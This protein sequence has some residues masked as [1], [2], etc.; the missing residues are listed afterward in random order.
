MWSTISATGIVYLQVELNSLNS[1]EQHNSNATYV[2]SGHL[3]STCYF[4]W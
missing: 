1:E 3:T 2:K 4:K